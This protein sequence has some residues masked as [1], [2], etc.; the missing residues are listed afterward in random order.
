VGRDLLDRA[1]RLDPGEPAY[2]LER[3][4]VDLESANSGS[5]ALP[6]LADATRSLERATE[7]AP[8]EADAWANLGLARLLSAMARER[9]PGL[10]AAS[11]SSFEYALEL[12]P[13]WPRILVQAA[14]VASLRGDEV[15]AT[16]LLDEARR[17]GSG[18]TAPAFTAG[19]N[20]R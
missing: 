20:E 19:G 16:A 14:G 12:R 8:L 1:S 18:L 3:G 17:L 5:S 11:Q 15:S 6:S 2:W 4:R 9:D 10:L 7:L 13:A